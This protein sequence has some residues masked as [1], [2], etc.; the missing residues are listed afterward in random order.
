MPCVYSVISSLSLSFRSL[1]EMVKISFTKGAML[2]EAIFN[3]TY[4]YNPIVGMET[5]P[6]YIL[7]NCGLC[8]Q[9]CSQ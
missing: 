3:G 8:S 2:Y 6:S 7:R 1:T 4:G 5:W 9:F